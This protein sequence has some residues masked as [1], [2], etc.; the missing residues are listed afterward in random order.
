MLAS[1]M[2]AQ[3]IS[4]KQTIINT[5]CITRELNRF[6]ESMR[7][8][9]PKEYS[10]QGTILVSKEIFQNLSTLDSRINKV[11]KIQKTKVSCSIASTAIFTVIAVS[12]L[13]VTIF[14]GS[15]VPC[16]AG[17]VFVGILSARS[18]KKIYQNH[19]Y[20]KSDQIA[21][22][23]LL[24]G[25]SGLNENNLLEKLKEKYNSSKEEGVE[26]NNYIMIALAYH[27]SKY[28]SE[29]NTGQEEAPNL[30]YK[31][32]RENRIKSI[33]QQIKDSD[34]DNFRIVAIKKKVDDDDTNLFDENETFLQIR[35]EAAHN[36]TNNQWY[37]EWNPWLSFSIGNDIFSNE[38]NIVE[39]ATQHSRLDTP[40]DLKRR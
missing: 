16:I 24:K 19:Q 2:K 5:F 26:K 21:P 3:L 7:T 32:A 15:G 20:F 12:L 9:K 39:K 28:V 18:F 40:F 31:E 1:T 4:M 13:A 37:P 38:F 29:K 25:I 35:D 11:K 14:F 6:V 27:L 36:E 8:H 22:L 17:I 23:D 33:I 30:G 34:V 10:L